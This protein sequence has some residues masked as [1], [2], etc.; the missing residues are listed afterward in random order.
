[1]SGR[2]P[3]HGTHRCCGSC[4]NKSTLGKMKS[5]ACFDSSRG[6]DERCTT[7]AHALLPTP[8][9]YSKQQLLGCLSERPLPTPYSSKRRS[10]QSPPPAIQPPR[11]WI[12]SPY[13]I[14]Q[15]G[16]RRLD[17][18]STQAPSGWMRWVDRLDGWVARCWIRLESSLQRQRAAPGW[19]ERSALR[20]A[21]S[22]APTQHPASRTQRSLRGGEMAWS[23]P[24]FLLTTAVYAVYAVSSLDTG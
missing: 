8:F 2:R 21:G 19:Q 18:A 22:S 12:Q 13:N 11:G 1:M 24:R 23:R 20:G 6:S 14:T 5:A 4:C 16:A 7:H 15:P 3:L 10:C 17:P 9:A